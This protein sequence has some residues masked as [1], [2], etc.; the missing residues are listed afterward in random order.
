MTVSDSSDVKPFATAA[1]SAA[2]VVGAGVTMAAARTDA[3]ATCGVA[4]TGATT[5]TA[6]SGRMVVCSGDASA[7]FTWREVTAAVGR[8]A[9]GTRSVM[10]AALLVDDFGAD[11]VVA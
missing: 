6:D 2:T 7:L 11:V 9:V 10:S 1:E 4:A 8:N 3:A 5:D